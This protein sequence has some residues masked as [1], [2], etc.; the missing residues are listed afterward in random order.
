LRSNKNLIAVLLRTLPDELASSFDPVL[1]PFEPRRIQL[2]D[3]V[4]SKP[5]D[6]GNLL[7]I[8]VNSRPS[9]LIDF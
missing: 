5:N 9:I 7:S 8:G 4:G 1:H 3:I 2:K 6:P